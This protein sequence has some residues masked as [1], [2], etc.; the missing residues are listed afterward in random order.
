VHK[1]VATN[2]NLTIWDVNPYNNFSKPNKQIQGVRCSKW[3]LTSVYPL[4]HV[5]SSCYVGILEKVDVNVLDIM[6]LHQ[7]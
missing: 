4:Y 2:S 5:F 1:S 6:N 7:K 3:N